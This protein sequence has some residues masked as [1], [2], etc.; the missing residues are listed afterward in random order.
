MRNKID[1]YHGLSN[2][3]PFSI[4]KTDAKSVVTIHD[5]IFEHFPH[6][7][8]GVDRTLYDV[9]S[10]FAV[11][12]AD[13]IVAASEMLNAILLIIIKLLLIKYMLFI[14]VVMMCFSMNIM[15]I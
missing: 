6:H 5:L 1:V 4:N 9:K 14:K 11:N 7:Y 12:H 10:K 8:P 2:E 15:L 3:L 13:I